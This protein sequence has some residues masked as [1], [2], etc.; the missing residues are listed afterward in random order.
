MA[1]AIE[2]AADE[3]ALARLQARIASGEE[4]VL[5][6]AFLQRE[7]AGESPLKLW[8]EHRGMT[9]LELSTASGVDRPYISKLE[10]GGA[11][12]KTATCRALAEALGIAMEDLV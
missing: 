1:R 8:R 4:E 6:W 9:Q 11:I 3:T 7:Q 5:P 10:K 2:D 12:N